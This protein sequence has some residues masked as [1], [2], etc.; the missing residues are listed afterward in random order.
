MPPPST[1]LPSTPLPI[2]H[3]GMEDRVLYH[4]FEETVEKSHLERTHRPPVIALLSAC[5]LLK[6]QPNSQPLH[7]QAQAT[8]LFY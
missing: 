7:L 8:L 3:D 5:L 6:S 2:S 4:V 1:P